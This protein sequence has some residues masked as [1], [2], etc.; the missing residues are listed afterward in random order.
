MVSWGVLPPSPGNA[1][2]ADGAEGLVRHHTGDRDLLAPS[3]IKSFFLFVHCEAFSHTNDTYDRTGT[4][5]FYSLPSES[6][7]RSRLFHIENSM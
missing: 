2:Q 3:V 6:R 5:V 4:F 7:L 1:G